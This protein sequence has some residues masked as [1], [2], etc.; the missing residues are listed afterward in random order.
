MSFTFIRLQPPF[1]DLHQPA[2]SKYGLYC[3]VT[4]TVGIIPQLSQTALKTLLMCGCVRPRMELHL[5]GL[6][7][8]IHHS[9]LVHLGA[10]ETEALPTM[11]LHLKTGKKTV[12]NRFFRF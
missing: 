2:D 1:V 4:C 6:L 12:G 8:H 11:H 10:W 3:M 5:F 7:G 9:V